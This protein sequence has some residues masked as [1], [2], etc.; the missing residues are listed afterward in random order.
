MQRILRSKSYPVNH[1]AQILALLI[2]VL[3]AAL[4]NDS[5]AQDESHYLPTGSPRESGFR[6]SL[7]LF[8]EE[9]FIGR[10]EAVGRVDLVPRVSGHIEAILFEEG[11]DVEKG[12]PLFRVDP[13]AF[14]IAVSEAQASL[15]VKRLL[16]QQAQNEAVRARGLHLGNAISD[17][18]LEEAE[19]RLAVASAEVDRAISELNA[20][21]LRLEYTTVRAPISGRIGRV[22]IT[23]GNFVAENVANVLATIVTTEELDV[24]VDVSVRELRWSEVG[25]SDAKITA[26]IY[27]SDTK[28]L[29]TAAPVSFVNNEVNSQT[30]TLRLRARFKA[31]EAKLTPGQFALVRLGRGPLVAANQPDAEISGQH[32]DSL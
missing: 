19:T 9:A 15:S 25:N 12:Q 5:S 7:Q 6:E 13:R 3:S 14:E 29:L 20:A 8:S 16:M 1:A 23:E 28:L 26:L 4:V 10:I 31:S 24:H 32:S 2:A 18:A 11:Q 22:L 17:E 30:G 21:T 27:D